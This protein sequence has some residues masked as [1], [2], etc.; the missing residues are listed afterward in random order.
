MKITKDQAEE[1]LRLYAVNEQS[2]AESN[3]Q[4]ENELTQ[5]KLRYA[6][7]MSINQNTMAEKSAILEVYCR[8]NI[9]EENKTIKLQYGTISF[10]LKPHAVVIPNKETEA[11]IVKQMLNSDMLGM[12]VKKVTTLSINREML[13]QNRDNKALTERLSDVMIQI[14]QENKFYIKVN[15]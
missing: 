4:M 5:V 1:A 9:T 6:D 11:V 3:A 15:K 13:I 14:K 2:F 10:K 8:E 12:Y 7:R